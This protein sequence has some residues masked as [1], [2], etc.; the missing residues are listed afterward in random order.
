VTPARGV[1]VLAVVLA[2][3][4][5]ARAAEPPPGALDAAML[6]DLDVV[7]SPNYARDRELGRKLGLVERLRMLETLRQME[8]EAVP[9]ARPAGPSP[10]PSAP[11]E[12]K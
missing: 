7:A 6:R 12:V 5:A 8:T 11:R 1:L 4:P 10:A 9:A 2:S 3:A